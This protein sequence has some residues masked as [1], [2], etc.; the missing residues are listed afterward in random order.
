MDSI[1]AEPQVLTLIC[2]RPWLPRLRADGLK[3]DSLAMMPS[4]VA[5]SS[6][7][8]VS[9]KTLATI[10]RTCCSGR[11][12]VWTMYSVRESSTSGEGGALV[13]TEL[14]KS[15][16]RVR[17]EVRSRENKTLGAFVES[18]VEEWEKKALGKRAV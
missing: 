14:L 13:A 4:T 18:E 15:R 16:A 1:P 12:Q 10:W 5:A 11:F 9:S 7:D 2:M 17:N 6:S 3:A 8:F